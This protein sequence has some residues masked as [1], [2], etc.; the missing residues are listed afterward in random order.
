MKQFK[1]IRV[2]GSMFMG[3]RIFLVKAIEDLSWHKVRSIES[4]PSEPDKMDSAKCDG[5]DR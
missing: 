5:Q 2:L 1:F 4:C 3:L